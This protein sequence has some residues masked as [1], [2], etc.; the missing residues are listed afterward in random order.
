MWSCFVFSTFTIQRCHWQQF[1][2]EQLNVTNTTFRRI[3]KQVLRAE[4]R[5][6]TL[7]WLCGKCSVFSSIYKRWQLPLWF[8]LFSSIFPKS[9]CPTQALR[10][11][12]CFCRFSK[13]LRTGKVRVALVK[14]HCWQIMTA[15]SIN[16]RKNL[17]SATHALCNFNRTFFCHFSR[18]WFNIQI[19]LQEL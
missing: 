10:R 5:R 4:W 8:L 15:K 12:W 1:F 3:F 16:F 14:L 17:P 7:I 2:R 19:L 13:F 9:A 18:W 6:C 11:L